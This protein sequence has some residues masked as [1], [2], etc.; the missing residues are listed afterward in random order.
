M[1]KLSKSL[2]AVI[3][4][5][6]W[7]GVVLASFLMLV[8]AESIPNVA[9]LIFAVVIFGMSLA[10]PIINPGIF[11]KQTTAATGV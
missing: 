3:S 1:N 7:I 4:F 8:V 11:V 10:V 6:L 5:W 2:A 9:V